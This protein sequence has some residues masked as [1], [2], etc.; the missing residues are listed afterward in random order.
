MNY[1]TEI[2]QGGEEMP[3]Y[4]PVYMGAYNR[5]YP[6]DASDI[7][8]MPVIG[9]TLDSLKIGQLGSVLLMGM[10]TN[11]SWKW[12]PNQPIYTSTVAG[13]LTQIPPTDSGNQVQVVAMAISETLIIFKPTYI[14][15]E[16]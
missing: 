14:L 13:E 15:V 11:T 5:W 6:A 1:T 8:K 7:N 16:V 12:V 2:F 10:I 4:T 9:L 3:P